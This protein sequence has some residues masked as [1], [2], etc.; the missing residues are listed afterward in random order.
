M[1]LHLRKSKPADIQFMTEMLYEAVYWRPNPCK[2]AFDEALTDPGFRKALVDWGARAGDTAVIALVDTQLAGAAWYRF[3]AD[4]NFIRGYINETIPVIVIAVH[5]DYRR[6]GIGQKMMAWLVDAASERNIE[7]LSLMVS[8][9]NHA[10]KLYEKCGFLEYADQN[11]SL[12]MLR[13]SKHTIK[14]IPT[15]R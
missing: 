6:K 14:S 11:D 1:N 7:K 15:W 13:R 5:Q 4:D 12:L 9:D 2:P 8:K 10:I 3:Y